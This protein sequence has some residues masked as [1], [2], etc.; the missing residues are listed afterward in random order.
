MVEQVTS[1]R[2]ESFLQAP[3]QARLGNRHLVDVGLWVLVVTPLLGKFAIEHRT[4]GVVDLF[5]GCASLG[6][7]MARRRWPV[8]TLVVALIGA[9]IC[10][11]MVKRPT[12]FIPVI[13][14]LLFTVT[15]RY[16]RATAIR[17]GFVSMLTLLG[18]VAILV[19]SKFFGP[20]LLAGFAWPLLAVA[21]GDAA[22]SRREAIAAADERALRAE[23]SREEEARRRVVE[24]RLHIAR[25]LHDV[26]AHQIAVINVQAGV[27]AH[28]MDSKPVQASEALATVRSSARVVLDE[29]A[30]ILSVLRTADVESERFPLG[31]PNNAPAPTL[32]QIPELVASF[33]PAGLHVQ[34][35]SSG[36][37]QRV[38]AS[39][40]IA[41]YRTIQEALTNAHKHGDGTARLRVKHQPDAVD[42]W[43]TNTTAQGMKPVAGFGLIGMRERV[44]ATGGTVSAA[45][46][47]GGKFVVHARFPIGSVPTVTVLP[48]PVSFAPPQENS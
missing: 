42:V 2:G 5:A 12:A 24:E 30:G 1:S 33:V 31:S 43:V 48:A 25:E 46:E 32:D 44:L 13:V 41:V 35:E 21:A 10:T 8:P 20:E 15:V 28:L 7:I 3:Q 17:L 19:S 40:G 38:S 23:E 45:D 16:N 36:E 39:I 4:I 18:C 26:I 9:V 37:P 22:R 11:W 29:L 27:A 6:L 34:F 47:G 14:V